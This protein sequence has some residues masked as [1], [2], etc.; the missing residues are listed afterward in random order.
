MNITTLGKAFQFLRQVEEME[1]DGEGGLNIMGRLKEVAGATTAATK[2][3]SD[4]LAQRGHGASAAAV[5]L[6][7]YV[8]AAYGAKKVYESGPV[9]RARAW[10]AQRQYEKAVRAQGGYR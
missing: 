2:A 7:P 6:L 9:Q 3:M 10:N 5:R 1:K 4:T 8:G